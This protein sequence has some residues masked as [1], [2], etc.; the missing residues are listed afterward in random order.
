MKGIS[1]REFGA[2]MAV[3]IVA[4]RLSPPEA[5]GRTGASATGIDEVIDRIKENLG[6]E[7]SAD[8]VDGVKAGDPSRE[9][10]GIVTTALA[11]VTVLRQAAE[12]GANFVITSEPTFYS[13]T[14]APTPPAGRGGRGGGS[15]SDDPPAADAVYAAKNALI[16]ESGL[17]VFRLSDHWGRRSPDPFVR[18]FATMFGWSPSGSMDGRS[19]DVPATTLDAL[20]SDLKSTLGTRGGIR[21]IGERETPVRTVGLLPGSTPITASLEVLPNVDVVI[22]GEVRE[23]ESAEYARD[24]VYSGQPKG[25][26]LLGRIVSEEPGMRRMAEWLERFVTEVPVQHVATMDPYWRPAS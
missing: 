7:W 10:T 18:G 11:T 15:V 16:E 6:V 13:R 21:V 22:A 2:M 24:A 17:V 8:T 1:R 4:G 9:A 26:V 23:W 19:Y 25:L 12:R 20:A 14:D 5:F 3:G